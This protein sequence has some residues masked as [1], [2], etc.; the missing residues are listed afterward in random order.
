MQAPA[1]EA[2]GA[3]AGAGAGAAGRVTGS[4]PAPIRAVKVW[5]AVPPAPKAVTVML[6][7]PLLTGAT[8]S[9]SGARTP[10]RATPL[11]EDV[12][13]YPSTGPLKYS[14]TNTAWA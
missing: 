12:A 10:A 13:E 9:M 7:A 6:T 3:G 4:G 1:R 14:C 2:R 11:S 5:E 8:I